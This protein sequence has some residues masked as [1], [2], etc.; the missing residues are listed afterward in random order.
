MR[1]IPISISRS[2]VLLPAV[3]LL[4]CGVS[5]AQGPTYKLG[6]TPTEA[7]VKAWDH[8]VGPEGKELPAGSGSAV[9]GAKLFAARCSFCHGKNA[10]GI[11]PWPRLAGGVGTLNTPTPIRSS[12]SYLPYAT[13]I[14]DFI[15]RAMP[16]DAEGTLSP[17][18]VYAL[19][20]FILFK[21]GTIKETDVLDK[22]SLVE[23][24]MPNRD[25]FFPT[26]PQANADKDHSWLPF[27]DQV[28]DLRKEDKAFDGK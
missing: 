22:K 4:A 26:T 14:W 19:T 9:E 6:R 5:W 25:G 17:S 24:K 3:L 12:G 23:I 7:E 28:K 8:A 18:E 16:R 21:N 20:A 15:N 27:W 1:C 2:S 11:F 10:E 13:T